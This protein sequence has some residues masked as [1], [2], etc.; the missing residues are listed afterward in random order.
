MAIMTLTWPGLR[1]CGIPLMSISFMSSFMLSSVAMLSLEG[2][3]KI[4]YW[5]TF[6]LVNYN[7][8]EVEHEEH[9]EV[10]GLFDECWFVSNSSFGS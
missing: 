2:G 5:S 9:Q 6:M 8:P 7:L 4:N 10:D 1:G 3:N